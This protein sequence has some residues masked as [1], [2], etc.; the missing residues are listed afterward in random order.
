MNVTCPQCSTIYRVDPE[1]VPA[2]G[3]NARCASCPGVFRVEPSRSA[4]VPEES[5]QTPDARGVTRPVG[6]APLHGRPGA[7]QKRLRRAAAGEAPRRKSPPGWAIHRSARPPSTPHR[8]EM[9]IRPWRANRLRPRPRRADPRRLS[10]PPTRR[11]ERSG[12]L[13]RSFPISWCIT[14]R[15][16][17]EAAGKVR[18]GRSSGRRSGRAGRSTSHRWAMGSRRRRRSSATRSTRSSRVESG[19]SERGPLAILAGA[20]SLPVDFTAC[21]IEG[22]SSAG[23]P[24]FYIA[25][26]HTESFH[27]RR[28]TDRSRHLP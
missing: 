27:D 25:L 18:S 7:L 28:K 2:G 26:F 3:V 13:G 10:A 20:R 4:D 19:C 9:R 21:C 6:G 11:R 15:G 14:P 5:T 8:R 16:G 17:I 23:G 12:W 1:K 22:L 24:S